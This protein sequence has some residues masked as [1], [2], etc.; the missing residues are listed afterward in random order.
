VSAAHAAHQNYFRDYS[1][2]IGRYVESDPIGLKGRLN[3]Y[4]YVDGNPVA[5]GDPLGLIIPN[6]IVDYLFTRPWSKDKCGSLLQAINNA[7]RDIERRHAAIRTNPL[8]LPQW[9]PGS[10]SSN[11]SSVNGHWREINRLD[12]QR[13]KNEQE[14]DRHC[15]DNCPPGSPAVDPVASDVTTP[16]VGALGVL[17]L[18]GGLLIAL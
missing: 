2:A 6:S 15:R 7:T 1:P 5:Y 8:T 12:S 18:V 16:T 13:R 4:A 14:Y 10:S 11:A 9:G 3:T 17:L